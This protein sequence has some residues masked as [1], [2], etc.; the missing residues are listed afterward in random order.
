MTGKLKQAFPRASRWLPLA[1]LL[2]AF[3]VVTFSHLDA[4][5]MLVWDEADYACLGRSLARGEGYAAPQN[6]DRLRPPLLPV[7]IA[8]ALLVSGQ[9]TDVAAKLPTPLFAMLAIAAVYALTLR[10]CG[11]WPAFAAAWCLAVGPEFV[12]RADML[13]SETPFLALHTIALG[14]FLL[15]FEGRRGWFHVGWAAFALA[16][17][18][19]YTALLF[20]PTLALIAVYELLRGNLLPA[21]RTRA[22]WLSP[23]WAAA[24]L[25]PWFYRQWLVTGDALSGVK[26]ASGQIPDYNLATMP[27][28]FYVSTLPQVMTWPAALLGCLGLA[29]AVWKRR[30]LGVYAVIATV[31]IVG[32]HT[33]YA[34]KEVRLIAGAWP[35]FAIGAGFAVEAWTLAVANAKL[36][37][38]PAA[39]LA[40]ALALSAPRVHAV[41]E[42]SITL[43]EPSF[44]DA[45]AYLKQNTRVGGAIVG[46]NPSQIGWYADREARPLP[47]QEEKFWAVAEGAEW[48]VVTNFERGQPG[49]V[50]RYVRGLTAADRLE[51]NVAE[52]ADARFKTMAVR[53]ERVRGEGK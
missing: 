17:A 44:L 5:G 16:L 35:L 38:A 22:F 46:P 42:Q 32:W 26:R 33:Q 20:G 52:F 4:F 13:L 1:V 2:A 53:V 19:R 36:R 34:F 48:L 7:S 15:G 40:A 28:D 45:M 39:L 49:Y 12:T 24:I 51:G 41:F 43:G 47:Q 37:Y 8:A 25:A 11:V 50:L 31:V 9:E 3:G 23:L 10:A 6:A 27:W 21:L 29:Y 18:T 30:P 14:A